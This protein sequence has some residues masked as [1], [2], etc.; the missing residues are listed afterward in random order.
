LSPRN[1]LILAGATAVSV[2]LAVGAVLSRDVPI[3]ATP[4]G[5]PLA[6]DLLDRANEVR[7]V[8][9]TGPGAAK[10]TLVSGEGGWRVAEKGNYPAKPA[11]VRELVLQLA[12]LRL[13]EAKTAQA[14]KLP[15]LELEDPGAEGAKSRLV[16]LLGADGKPLASAVVGKTRFGLYGGG[17]SGVYVRHPGES[18]AWLAAGTLELPSDALDVVDMQVIDLPLSEVARVVLDP[19][20]AEIV[21]RRSEAGADSFTV[22]A[23]P[24]EG[25]QFDTAKAEEVAG[26]LGALSMQDV[27]PAKELTLPPEVRRSRVETLDGLVVDV[28]V[29][30]LG[31]G[32]AAES[33]VQLSASA[34]EPAAAAPATP[35]TPAPAG[36]EA[37]DGESPKPSAA[38]RAAALQAR[39]AGWAFKVPPYLGDRLGATLDSLLAEPGAS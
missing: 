2:A 37:A 1:F 22:D 38:E 19:G 4:T 29:A 13:V 21:V 33:W 12:N 28:T 34:K 39:F 25:R 5:A 11:K 36:T 18:Q 23:A 8:R 26:M 32:E 6:E 24:P 35:A 31:E 7:T 17:R 30:K 15:R 20:G 9:I 27:K 10:L 3:T 14:D 16:E